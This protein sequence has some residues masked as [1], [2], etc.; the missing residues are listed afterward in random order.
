VNTVLELRNDLEP[1]RISDLITIDTRAP[2]LRL[3]DRLALRVGLALLL[4]GQR[5]HPLADP[6]E[7]RRLQLERQS[8]ELQRENLVSRG[9]LY[10]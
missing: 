4:W 5:R 7:L 3:T 9:H 1:D 10:R 8:A 6:Q 2:E